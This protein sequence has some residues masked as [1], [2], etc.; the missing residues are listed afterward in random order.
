MHLHKFL[1]INKKKCNI[2]KTVWYD[3][4][5]LNKTSL[6]MPRARGSAC[7]KREEAKTSDTCPQTIIK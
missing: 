7:Q 1:N 3:I 6:E 5:L 2:Q 4:I